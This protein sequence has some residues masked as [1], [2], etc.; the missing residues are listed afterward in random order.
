MKRAK[1]YI[2]WLIVAISLSLAACGSTS[3]TAILPEEE[4]SAVSTEAT[5]ELSITPYSGTVRA[6]DINDDGVVGGSNNNY[7]ESFTLTQAAEIDITF[8]GQNGYLFPPGSARGGASFY[9]TGPGGFYVFLSGRLP[10]FGLPSV[11]A[12]GAGD[13][14]ILRDVNDEITT[15]TI[16]GPLAAGSYTIQV[17]AANRLEAPFTLDV[18]STS[19]GG[20]GGISAFRQQAVDIALDEWQFWGRTER[21]I[22]GSYVRVGATET[23]SGFDAR[24]G[25]YWQAAGFN[26]DGDD[27][28][29]PWSA[30]FISWVMQEAGAGNNFNYSANHAAYINE[31]VL[32]NKQG[33]LNAAFVGYDIDDTAPRIGDLVCYTRED[34]TTTFDSITSSTGFYT[35]HCDLVTALGSGQIEVIGGNV[36]NS[37]TKKILRTN[38]QGLVTDTFNRWFVVIR[39]NL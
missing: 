6:A 11:Y 39:A 34:A 36:N 23:Q 15:L 14:E 22:N 19:T 2:N 13:L 17:Q 9:L 5:T 29:Q 18:S 32:N 27:T 12:S 31:Y 26:F 28:D 16:T 25:D 30:A 24:V 7:S 1:E 20:G 33:N 4:V 37:V 8:S 21:N 35:S 38:G 10:L 3:S